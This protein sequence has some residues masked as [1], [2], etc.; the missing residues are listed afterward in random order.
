MINQYIKGMLE[1]SVTGV[2]LERFI[3]KCN[4]S[5]ITLYSVSRERYDLMRCTVNLG[6]FKKIAVIN[7]ELRCRIRVKRRYGAKFLVN[8]IKRRKAFVVGAAIF[9]IFL[10]ILSSSIWR[11]DISGIDKVTATQI[12]D[13]V[14]DMNAGIGIFKPKCD[15]K[16]L[17]MAIRKE[18]PDVDW[19]IV[20][21]NGVVMR[22]R[23]VETVEGVKREDTTPSSIV[24]EVEGE[25]VYISV[26][27]GAQAVKVND[28]IKVGQTLINGIVDKRRDENYYLIQNAMGTV[29]AR[30]VY[31]GGASLK[32]DEV[33]RKV[34][35][36]NTEEVSYISMFGWKI[37]SKKES[38]YEHYDE[39]TVCYKVFS[40]NR[41]FPIYAVKR[42]Y[43]EYIELTDEQL[44]TKAREI[45]VKRALA[46]AGRCIPIG[47]ETETQNIDYGFDRETNTYYAS[48]EITAVHEI[49]VKR[50]LS[51][52]EIDEIIRSKGEQK[53]NE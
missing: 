26:L 1:I 48:A 28:K 44:E 2:N 34:Y 32:L 21:I 53:N 38:P 14:N 11:I 10:V 17:E 7:R 52:S 39:K 19:V 18:L 4:A 49:G 5:G 8:R 42:I 9:V 45:L 36:G 23:V 47:A 16:A 50:T 33:E 6:D 40:E 15:T 30:V 13:V 22:I 43:K 41:L 46:D 3:N 37:G 29:K 27:K 51:Q 35:T 24:S 12:L 20:D 25:I 31:K